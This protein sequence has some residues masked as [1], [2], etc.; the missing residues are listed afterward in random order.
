[1]RNRGGLERVN[2]KEREKT[3]K[4]EDLGGEKSKKNYSSDRGS[5]LLG[6]S[7]AQLHLS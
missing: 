1:M 5:G 3:G 6:G 7:A 4:R 2:I